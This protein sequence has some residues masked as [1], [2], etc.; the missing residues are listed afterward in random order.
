MSRTIEADTKSM[1]SEA[2]DCGKQ[3]MLLEVLLFLRH[4]GLH[5][6]AVELAE[7]YLSDDVQLINALK[8]EI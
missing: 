8:R 7:T 1:V 4:K 6:T 2:V 3:M 5:D